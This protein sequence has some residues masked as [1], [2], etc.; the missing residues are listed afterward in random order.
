MRRERA[1]Y[2]K[3]SN[4]RKMQFVPEIGH[5]IPNKGPV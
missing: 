2:R 3:K 5:I 4:K 1:F